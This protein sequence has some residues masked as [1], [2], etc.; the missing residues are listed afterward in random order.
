MINITNLN[1]Y[2]NKGK[3]NEIHVINET[4]LILPDKGLISFLGPSGSGKTT[5]LNVIGGLDS[6]RGSISY[7]D[8]SMKN[9]N[10]GLI[11]KYRKDNI[12][13]IFQNYNLL[14]NETVYNNL[15]IALELMGIIDKEEVDKRIEYTLKAVGMYKYR[16]KMAY[17]LSGGQQQRVAIARALLKNAKI[18]IADEPT[19]NLDSENTIEVM[20][21][22]KKISKTTLVLLVT[23]DINIANYYSD[24][25]IE[26]KD[27][28]IVNEYENVNPSTVLQDNSNNIYLKD[29]C[30]DENNTSLGNIKVYYDEEEKEEFNIEIVVRNG[31]YYI[32]SN[33]PIKLAETSNLRF[34]NEHSKKQKTIKV[35]ESNY[36]T[37]WFKDEKKGFKHF[38]TTI[39]KIVVG[40]FNRLR[41]VNKKGK[42]INLSLV[43]MGMLVALGVVCLINFSYV[44]TTSFVYADNNFMLTS[45][46][47]IYIED[48]V[49][50]IAENYEEGKIS[51]VVLFQP[52]T[53]LQ[54]SHR[55]TFQKDIDVEFETM[56]GQYDS[57][58]NYGILYG[59]IPTKRDEIVVDL[60]MAQ[61]I[62]KEFGNRAAIASV[63][64]KE[65]ILSCREL[66]L[67]VKIVGVIDGSHKAVFGTE[68]FYIDWCC[69]APTGNF[70][71]MRY[72]LKEVDSKGNPLYEVTSGRDIENEGYEILVPSGSKYAREEYLVINNKEFTVVGTYKYKDNIISS[73]SEEFITNIKPT[74]EE[75]HLAEGVCLNKDEYIIVEGNE[76][77]KI[78]E[79]I[80]SVYLES[81]KIGDV[82]STYKGDFTVVGKYNGTQKALSS[83][84]IQTK[85]SYILSNY[86]SRE[87]CFYINT[88]K[89]EL[90][91]KNDEIVLS[92]YEVN[93]IIRQENRES[94][95]ILYELLFFVLIFI[96]SIFAY[97]VMRS[98]MISLIYNI[99]VERSIGATKMTIISRFFTDII[100]ITT[101]YS[102]LG[103][104]MILLLYNFTAEIVNYYVGKV[105]LIREN[106][107]YFVGIISLYLVNIIFGLL[108]VISLL[109]KTPSEICAKYDI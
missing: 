42:L 96:C 55:L 18:I 15:V 90:T 103:Y 87:V 60:V 26:L 28:V 61:R 63:I 33:K 20:N 11:D 27:G 32:K 72:Y 59:S 21:I 83:L 45:S 106:S 95:I 14:P 30:C 89:G 84:F 97:F 73:L 62:S 99:G 104:V 81:Y 79:C 66:F 77:K 75:E 40:S 17:A 41:N 9:Y 105:F 8:I 50:S 88:S 82:I 67:E 1:K 43:F 98:R 12:G 101:V 69:L 70:G 10:V 92:L 22:L 109:R 58:K 37:T 100:L 16:K 7:D 25:I 36:D 76:P 54:V 80:V 24:R 56:V 107:Y 39:F 48:P 19:G 29:M 71:S 108:P 74:I 35:D 13:Y 47:H 34:L 2:Y 93:T 85:D 31:N 6:A 86:N 4:N 5:L 65:V 51:N 57:V 3:N 94:N 49:I 68:E 44:D 46:N 64:G 23:H 91:T 102:V 53:T 38:L 52:Q 78:N